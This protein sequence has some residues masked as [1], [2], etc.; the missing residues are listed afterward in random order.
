MKSYKTILLL[1]L[2]AVETVRTLKS[3]T[4]LII[5]KD[6]K[7][8]RVLKENEITQLLSEDANNLRH[9]DL[10]GLLIPLNLTTNGRNSSDIYTDSVYDIVEEQDILPNTQ[11]NI[12]SDIGT[13]M[14][15]TLIGIS[16]VIC[17]LMF[18]C[19]CIMNTV[20]GSQVNPVVFFD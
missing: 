9:V 10:Y 12:L 15:A 2:V 18:V 11:S 7:S 17:S 16:T 8:L 6:G 1:L 3:P 20:A 19:M 4:I 13:I 5:T 14:V